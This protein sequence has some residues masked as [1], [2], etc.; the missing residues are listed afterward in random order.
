LPKSEK[1]SLN[2]KNMKKF[3]RKFI[4]IKLLTRR[5]QF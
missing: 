2:V 1:M 4:F 5:E 3:S